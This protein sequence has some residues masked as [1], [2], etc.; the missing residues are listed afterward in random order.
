MPNAISKL[1]RGSPSRSPSEARK[2]NKRE[3]QEKRQEKIE[4]RIK[5]DKR[6]EKERQKSD[7]GKVGDMM[8]ISDPSQTQV[9]VQT[10]IWKRKRK[11]HKS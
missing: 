3:K 6:L 11:E 5:D 2:L 10:Q 8:A 1:R 4:Q 7:T 9:L